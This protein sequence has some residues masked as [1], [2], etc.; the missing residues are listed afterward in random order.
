MSQLGLLTCMYG[1]GAYRYDGDEANLVW[2]VMQIMNHALYK[3]PLFI[4]AG[5]ITH[6]TGK[7]L[8]NDVRG[9]W[10]SHRVLALVTIL[11]AYGLAGGPL[12]LSFT[13][14]EAFLY[15]VYHAAQGS[16]I[17]W[18]IGGMAILTAV[19]NVAIFWRILTTFIARAVGRNARGA[20][21]R[22]RA[23]FWGATIWWPAALLVALQFFGGIATSQFG[24]IV[25]PIE[26]HL[27]Y[28]SEL[29][30]GSFFYAVSHPGSTP[31]L[32][33]ADG[34]R[35]RHGGRA[36]PAVAQAGH[37]LPQH[38]IPEHIQRDG[39]SRG[40]PVFYAF[41]S[42]NLRWYIGVVLATLFMRVFA[43]DVVAWIGGEPIRGSRRVGSAAGFAGSAA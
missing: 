11:A 1:L 33:S 7:K 12:T 16:P 32:M 10:H 20:R 6:A 43:A 8:L 30:K 18:A 39:A 14:K 23:G 13:A 21:A 3:A 26:T 36:E 29:S 24:A 28:W 15:Q 34:D 42:G 19:F 31:F 35:S 9:L 37:G 22:T 41:Q 4:I 17:V 38:A 5:A 27:G 40:L 2:P 25:Q